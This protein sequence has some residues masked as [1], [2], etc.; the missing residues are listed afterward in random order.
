MKIIMLAMP[1]FLSGCGG[2]LRNTA[3]ISG[4]ATTCID[5][6]AYIQFPSG[7]SVKYTRD[8]KPEVCQ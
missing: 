6:V 5:G 4:H 3:M 7:A 8:G 2:C 1:L